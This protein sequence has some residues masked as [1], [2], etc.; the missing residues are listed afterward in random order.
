M[1]KVDKTRKKLKWPESGDRIR[2]ADGT[3]YRVRED[4]AWVRM[5]IGNQ[6]KEEKEK[7]RR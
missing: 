1:E 3:I 6:G 7:R 5:P 2:F 4:G